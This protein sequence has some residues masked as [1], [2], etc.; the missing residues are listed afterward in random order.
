M[1]DDFEDL[2]SEGEFRTF[3]QALLDL[4]RGRL[5]GPRRPSSEGLLWIASALLL[6]TNLLL[7]LTVFGNLVGGLG[8]ATPGRTLWVAL[9]MDLLGAGLLAWTVWDAAWQIGGRPGR[10]RRAAALLLLV[11]VGLTAIWRFALPAALGTNLEALFTSFLTGPVTGSADVRRDLPAMYNLF[12]I[13]IAAAT[14]F[15]AAHVLLAFARWT[16]AADDWVRGLPVYAW[17]L[18]AGISLLATVFIVLSFLYV[19]AGR[20]LADDFN[21]WLVAKMIVAPNVFVSGYASSLDLGRRIRSGRPEAPRW[22]ARL[23]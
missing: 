2:G 12:G 3:R 9:G 11:W 5:A 1:R 19:L 14:V 18:G 13:W 16:A 15:V 4:L 10:I 7:I 8:P 23:P 6:G 21:A 22:R 20:P 17:L